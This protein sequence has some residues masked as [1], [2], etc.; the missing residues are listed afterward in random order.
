MI[1]SSYP[2]SRLRRLR[3]NCSV[4]ELFRENFLNTSDLIAPLFIRENDDEKE[5]KS[6]PGVFRYSIKEI[7]NEV[8]E[9]YN[10][11]IKCVMLFP[12]TPDTLKNAEGSEALN[13]N[14]LVC[15]AVRKIKKHLPEMVVL[16]DVALDPYTDHGHDGL[17]DDN[18]Y[19]INDKTIE[20]LVGQSLNQIYAGADG[21]CPSDMMDGR[22]QAIRSAFEE[23]GLVNSLIVS[24]AVK[25]ATCFY[26]PFRNAVGAKPKGDKK[27]YQID[28]SNSRVAIQEVIQDIQEGADAVIIKP[29]LPYLDIIHRASN[30]NS[31]SVWAYQ[32]SGE[33]SSIKYAAQAG[34][35]NEKDAFLETLMCFKRA[36][37]SKIITYAAKDI[38]KWLKE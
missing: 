26:G 12:K 4:R 13:P 21:V 16:A 6:M 31:C 22:I 19:V 23:K 35:L 38:V 1:T 32:V 14:N 24:Y 34:I 11:G 17:C 27:S 30:I 8:L 33:Y 25:Y 5:I 28:P 29:G 18:G 37:A 3:T 36:G 20:V 2:N 7:E 15:N 10:L 9:L